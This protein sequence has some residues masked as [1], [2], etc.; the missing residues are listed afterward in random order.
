MSGLAEHWNGWQDLTKGPTHLFDI[1]HSAV[2]L[3][4]LFLVSDSARYCMSTRSETHNPHNTVVP[5]HTTVVRTF[6]SVQRP[7]P[8]NPHPPSPPVKQ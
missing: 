8:P 2:V 7:P 4:T 1:H 6:T 5:D 3:T